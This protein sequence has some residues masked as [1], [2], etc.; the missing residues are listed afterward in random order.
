MP[1]IRHT[2]KPIV[3]KPDSVP[4]AKSKI[5]LSDDR[6][7]SRCACGLS[8]SGT[9]DHQG[10]EFVKINLCHHMQYY[11]HYFRRDLI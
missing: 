9:G 1:V 5:Y 11:C 6:W 4:K 10:W 2:R 8:W 3:M 7:Y